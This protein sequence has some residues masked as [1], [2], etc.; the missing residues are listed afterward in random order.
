MKTAVI[1]GSEGQDGRYLSQTLLKHSFQV[2]GLDQQ[3]IR[4]NG[5]E[6]RTEASVDI[7]DFS[8]VS[9]F[10]QDEKP[11][12][13]YYLAA[14]HH[15]SQDH[16]GDHHRLIEQSFAVNV[17]GLSHFLEAVRGF[18]PATRIFYAGSSRMFGLARDS[19]QNESTP[20]NPQCIYG[21]TKLAGAQ[22]C[23]YFREKFHVFA[24]T[25]IMYNHESPL[26]GHQF[27]TQKIVQTAWRIKQ[28]LEDRLVLGDLNSRV[29]WGFAGDY[30]RA[31]ML[32]L[33]LPRPE[34]CVVATGETHSI[35]DFVEESFKLMGLQWQDFVVENSAVLNDQGSRSVLCGDSRKLRSLTGWEPEVDFWGLVKLMAEEVMKNDKK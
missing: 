23:Q 10:V 4:R 28:G 29:D 1:I 9:R 14:H 16:P 27:V 21:I 15:S 7:L 24:C 33:E 19:Q 34:D 17:K 22:L 3:G 31:M 11:D 20:F 8:A 18:S 26:R 32:M 2:T 35:R 25:G 5:G 13:L 30:V 6:L 12:H